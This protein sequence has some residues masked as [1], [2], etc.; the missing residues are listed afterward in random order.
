[1]SPVT[2][3]SQR[4]RSQSNKPHPTQ[5]TVI[6]ADLD[7]SHEKVIVHLADGAQIDFPVPSAQDIRDRFFYRKAKSSEKPARPPNKF[8]IF[9]TMLQGS[10]DALKLQVPIASGL[11]SE[12]WKKSSDDVKELF[13]KLA[14]RA[15]VEDSEINPG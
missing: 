15:K 2:T 13:T 4:Q 6:Y 7:N 10:I 3:Q 11:A 1:M 14:A 8:F 9:R 12:V 5:I